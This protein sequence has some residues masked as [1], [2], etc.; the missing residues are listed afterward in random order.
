[1]N[2]LDTRLTDAAEATRSELTIP[3]R[4]A[5]SV[6]RRS[7]TQRMTTVAASAFVVLAF[8]GSATI[9]TGAVGGDAPVG[10]EDIDDAPPRADTSVTVPDSVEPAVDLRAFIAE[11][12]VSSQLNDAFGMQNLIDGDRTTSWQDASLR[13]TGAQVIVR[14][15]EPVH[16]D[17]LVIAPLL[18]RDRFLRNYWVQDLEIEL[19]TDAGEI[20]EPIVS[21]LSRD[22]HEPERID[23]RSNAVRGLVLTVATTYPSQ[24][25]GKTPPFDELAIAEIEVWGRPADGSMTA[26]TTTTVPSTPRAQDHGSSGSF[27]A[28]YDEVDWLAVKAAPDRDF[29]DFDDEASHLRLLN[30]REAVS[31]IAAASVIMVR[32]TESYEEAFLLLDDETETVVYIG[33][34]STDTPLV[35]AM[36]T[37]TEDWSRGSSEAGHAVA[38][39]V[40]ANSADFVADAGSEVAVVRFFRLADEY[41]SVP[42]GTRHDELMRIAD[43]ILAAL[44][45]PPTGPGDLLGQDTEIVMGPNT[46]LPAEP[47]DDLVIASMVADAAPPIAWCGGEEPRSGTPDERGSHPSPSDALWSFLRAHG[48]RLAS[49]GFVEYELPDGTIVA[50][51]PVDGDPASSIAAI[52]II[53]HADGWTVTGWE[54]S[55]C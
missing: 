8:V 55:A 45:L 13:G 37:V 23:V 26:T 25:V 24:P 46:M 15:A 39:M 4:S 34:Q 5:T 49:S 41:A 10:G 48:E 14:F 29:G 33:W 47:S 51:Q 22:L 9:L 36:P 28:I 27:G 19:I 54:L 12:D 7:I 32:S 40:H 44:D 2:A 17:H 50:V 52:T 30:A 6:R 31:D 3:E 1:M 20:G 43:E 53:Q 35:V 21:R 38:D 16:V 18:D 42:L 11:V